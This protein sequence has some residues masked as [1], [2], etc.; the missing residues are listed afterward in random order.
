[1]II[2]SSGVK[3]NPYQLVRQAIA[4]R[5]SLIGLYDRYVRFF[6]PR[7]LGTDLAGKPVVI[8]YQ[9][10]GGRRGGLPPRG[11]WVCFDVGVFDSLNRNG[12][13][14]IAKPLPAKPV[15]PLKKVDIAA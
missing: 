4:D 11:D 15:C 6:S 5:V 14:W 8:A 2:E 12:D 10:G 3:A 9:Y 13:T 1:M 7:V